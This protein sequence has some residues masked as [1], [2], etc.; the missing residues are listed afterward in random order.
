MKGVVYNLLN[1]LRLKV[2]SNAPI[3]EIARM[4]LDVW[5]YLALEK[6]QR[7]QIILSTIL[8]DIKVVLKKYFPRAQINDAINS[9][10]SGFYFSKEQIAEHIGKIWY[11][12]NHGSK[13]FRVIVVKE[14]INTLNGKKFDLELFSSQEQYLREMNKLNNILA[15]ILQRGDKHYTDCLGKITP[16]MEIRSNFYSVIGLNY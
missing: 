4:Y 11:D 8:P 6:N 5:N 1:Q 9:V 14:I 15:P 10:S 16:F 7:N 3:P 2:N 13:K 12:W